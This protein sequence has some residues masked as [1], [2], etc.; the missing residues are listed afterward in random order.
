MDPATRTPEHEFAGRVAIVTGAAGGIGLAAVQL[1]R[2][3]GARVVAVDRDTQVQ[4][5]ACEGIVPLV[6]DVADESCAEQ[7]VSMALEQFGR[8]DL[9]I[10][11]AGII[12]NVPVSEMR[13]DEWNRVLAVN[14]TGAFLF[15]RAAL[16]PMMAAGAGA[17]VNVGSYACYQAPPPSPPTP[18]RRARWPSSPAHWHWKRFPMASASMPSHRGTRSPASATHCTRTARPSSPSMA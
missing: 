12:I 9:L 15:S 17:I 2:Q 16:A 7:A 11:N 4:A 3:R 6:G 8:L 13:L 14:A 5:L 1:L 18:R 10:N